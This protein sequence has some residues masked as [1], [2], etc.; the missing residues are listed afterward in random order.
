[1]AGGLL[2]RLTPEPG[3][4]PAVGKDVRTAEQELS[5]MHRQKLTFKHFMRY[6]GITT[7]FP[8]LWERRVLLSLS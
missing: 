5:W 4:L 7:F 1:M 8:G 3:L 6:Q 2:L